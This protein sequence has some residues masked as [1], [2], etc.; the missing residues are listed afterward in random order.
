MND[1][2]DK[3]DFILIEFF[4]VKV[5]ARYK[6]SL[7]FRLSLVCSKSKFSTGIQLFAMT[8]TSYALVD[9]SLF[10]VPTKYEC[11][12]LIGLKNPSI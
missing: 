3:L 6:D 2:S 1:H 5:R 12:K 9:S 11:A 7:V 10:F 8:T 4:L